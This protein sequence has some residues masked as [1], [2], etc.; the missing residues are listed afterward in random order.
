M[1]KTILYRLSKCD[2][3]LALGSHIQK[4]MQQ[5]PPWLIETYDALA[6]SVMSILSNTTRRTQ[7]PYAWDNNV[8]T[9]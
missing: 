2:I 4:Q 8:T 9:K 6:M 3:Q 5:E 7:A 1:N